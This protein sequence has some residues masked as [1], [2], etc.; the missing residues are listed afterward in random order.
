VELVRGLGLLDG[1]LL[2]VGGPEGGPLRRA[3][4]YRSPTPGT[5]PLVSSWPRPVRRPTSSGDDPV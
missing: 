5:P 1:T 4:T 3:R 2:I